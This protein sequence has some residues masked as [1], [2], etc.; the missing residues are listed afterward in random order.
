MKGLQGKLPILLSI[1]SVIALIGLSVYRFREW[2]GLRLY[3]G[4]GF[5]GLY[6]LWLF[7]ESRIAIG[8]TKKD[9]TESDRGTLELYA[10]GRA[11]TVLT[12]LGIP[13]LW[14]WE[15]GQMILG[16]AVFVIATT[17]RLWSIRVLGQFYSHRVRVTDEH[18]IV[19]SGPYRVIRH[20]AYTGMLAAHAGFVVFFFNWITLAL[21]L[22]FFIPAVIMRIRVE[23]KTLLELP[24]YSEYCKN[25]KRLIPLIW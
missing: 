5:V 12:G 22:L 24:G 4:I 3:M 15:P 2:T 18:R 1:I 21:L 6:L 14:Y 23:E 9:S 8:E 7:I 13:V 16:T 17:F 19:D 20:P 10:A 11:A 25:R